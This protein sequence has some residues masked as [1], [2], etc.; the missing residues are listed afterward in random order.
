MGEYVEKCNIS[1][2]IERMTRGWQF[3]ACLIAYSTDMYIIFEQL[4]CTHCTMNYGRV[5]AVG[6]KLM[7][8]YWS[9]TVSTGY[10]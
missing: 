7:D 6:H 10:P 4:D 1:I 5:S 2:L 3:G 8:M 9:N